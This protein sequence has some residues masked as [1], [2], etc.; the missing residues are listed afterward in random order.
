MISVEHEYK[1]KPTLEKIKLLVVDRIGFPP[2]KIQHS[3][4]E[5]VLTYR[6][7]AYLMIGIWFHA[8]TCIDWEKTE[9]INPAVIVEISGYI[10]TEVRKQIF[11]DAK[12]MVPRDIPYFTAVGPLHGNCLSMTGV[13]RCNLANVYKNLTSY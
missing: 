7:G 10:N 4:G 12:N 5:I 3:D 13:Q 9:Y 11:L 1:Y 2:D 8:N 6:K